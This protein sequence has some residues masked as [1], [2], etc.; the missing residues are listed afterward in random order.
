VRGLRGRQQR[1]FLATLL[2]SQGVPLLQA[3]DEPGRTQQ[4]NNNAYCQDNEISWINWANADIDLVEFAR[5]L[6]A[7][8]HEHLVFRR[9]RFFRGP[10]RQGE[11]ADIVWF[12]PSGQQMDE[13]DWDGENSNAVAVF[14]NGEAITEPDPRGQPI[15]DDSFLLLFNPS[16]DEASFAVPAPPYHGLW[17]IALDTAAIPRRSNTV[18]SHL[19]RVEPHSLRV[20]RR[21]A[22]GQTGGSSM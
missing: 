5:L 2:L 8:R 10:R 9:R 16:R 3:G 21:S 1:N 12:S 17:E 20:L 14:L 7:F 4:G 15:R 18:S 11:M 13:A 19:V 22:D 6:I